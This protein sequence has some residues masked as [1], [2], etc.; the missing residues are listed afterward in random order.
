MWIRN[1]LG[2]ILIIRIPET[3][4]G[5]NMD[6]WG[7]VDSNKKMKLRIVMTEGDP[8]MGIPCYTQGC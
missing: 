1:D 6:I 7:K 5:V 4:Q 3:D 8:V 2:W